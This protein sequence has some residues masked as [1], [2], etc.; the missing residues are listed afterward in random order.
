MLKDK[1]SGCSGKRDLGDEK[2]SS[3]FSFGKTEKSK[4]KNNFRTFLISNADLYFYRNLDYF[5]ENFKCCHLMRTWH[6]KKLVETFLHKNFNV[7]RNVNK[8][9]C[10]LK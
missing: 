5:I 1:K 4:N 3:W 2:P 7:I 6:S 8:K 9:K 10:M